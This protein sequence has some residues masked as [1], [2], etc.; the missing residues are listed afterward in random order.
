MAKNQ[1][2]KDYG[3]ILI[4]GEKQRKAGIRVMR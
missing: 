1:K 3:T 2:I 4:T